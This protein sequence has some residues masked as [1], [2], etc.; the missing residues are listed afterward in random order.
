MRTTFDLLCVRGFDSD[1]V[2]KGRMVAMND[3]AVE[4]S[5]IIRISGRRKGLEE[6]LE[7]DEDEEGREVSVF[8]DSKLRRSATRPHFRTMLVTFA[9]YFPA[10]KPLFIPIRIDA[11]AWVQELSKAIAEDLHSRG[12]KDVKVDDIRLFKVNLFLLS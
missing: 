2:E 6:R 5:L 1:S 3:D 4:E 8:G 7:D 10:E 12:R 11:D 9:C